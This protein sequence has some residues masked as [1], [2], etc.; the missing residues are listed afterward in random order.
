[1]K[2]LKQLISSLK[3]DDSESIETDLLKY[4]LSRTN[5]TKQLK[6]IAR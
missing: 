5:D 6:K 2:T 1:M 3:N 4:Q